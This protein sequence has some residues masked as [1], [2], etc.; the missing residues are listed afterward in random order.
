MTQYDYKS[1]TTSTL[2]N[3][4]L[5]GNLPIELFRTDHGYYVFD[6]HNVR[7][8]TLDEVSYDILQILRKRNA[9][10]EEIVGLL[11]QH[12]AEQV[13]EAYNELMSI[14]KEGFLVR[15]SFNRVP[16]FSDSDVRMKQRL[17]EEMSGL[18][19]SITGKCNLGCSYC[20]YGGQYASQRKLAGGS[21]SW[22]TLKN[23]MIFLA[24]HSTRSE[25]LQLDFF[26]GE[27]MLE[28]RLIKRAIVFFKSLIS[29]RPTKVDVTIASNGTLLN[30]E[31]L[32]FLVKH[33]VYLQ[34]SI[35]G[36]RELHDRHRVFKSSGRG[37]FDIIMENLKKIYGYDEKYYRSY[38]RIKSV[39]TPDQGIENDEFWQHPLIKSVIEEGHLSVLQ[40]RPHFDVE[41]DQ[42]YF[43]RLQRIGERA[44]TLRDVSTLDDVRGVLSQKE[45][46]FFQSTIAK[47][48][49]VQAVYNLYF[50]DKTDIPFTKGC[51]Y[52]YKEGNVEP[53]GKITVCHLSTNWVIGDVNEGTWFFD[54][55]V[56]F[57][58]RITNWNHCS[59]CF[60]QRFCDACPEKID[61]KEESYSKSRSHFCQF[62]RKNYRAIFKYA[63]GLCEQNPG[64]W[65]EVDRL[66]E[67][68]YKRE[69][70]KKAAAA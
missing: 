68:G 23:A 50:K 11:T 47:F 15:G 56:K 9:G 38:I 8:A 42:E 60:V 55:I 54:D 27:P 64:F 53:S 7:M 41:K 45:M 31:I 18:T 36:N 48:F 10:V 63:L 52:G 43:E 4:E 35:D 22:E 67:V 69:E 2:P 14:Q 20:I 49:D 33:N 34:F 57:D 28:F 21:M 17:S 32:E 12:P 6:A 29:N 25:S 58:R 37:S 16:R 61:G 65:N 30:D 44:L 3:N 40:L 70:A 59:G 24:H 1:K 13:R 19:I 39:Q 66:I 26:G 46:R 62:Q 5:F 51:L